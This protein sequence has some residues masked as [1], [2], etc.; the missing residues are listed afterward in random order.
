M[1]QLGLIGGLS[2]GKEGPAVHLGAL[3][4]YLSRTMRNCPNMVL[5]PFDVAVAGAFRQYFKRPCG[6]FCF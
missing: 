6:V 5:K 1:R 2:I 3:R 4:K